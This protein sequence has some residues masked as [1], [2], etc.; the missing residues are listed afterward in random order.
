VMRLAAVIAARLAESKIVNKYRHA[1][2]KTKRKS[3][4]WERQPGESQIAFEWPGNTSASAENGQLGGA[5]R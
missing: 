3:M 5:K 1:D 2:M 4:P